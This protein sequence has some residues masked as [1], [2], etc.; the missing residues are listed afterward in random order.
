VS[1]IPKVA[2]QNPNAWLKRRVAS[3]EIT[4]PTQDNRLI[5]WPDTKLMVANPMVNMGGAF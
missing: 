4:T 2:S 3:D 5:A 1:T